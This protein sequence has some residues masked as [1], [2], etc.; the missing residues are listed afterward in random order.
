[1]NWLWRL[2]VPAKLQHFLWLCFHNALP[3]NARRHHC[4]MVAS[5]SCT[6]CSSPIED[7][8]HCLR[9]CPHSIEFWLGLNMGGGDGLSRTWNH[10]N[11]NMVTTPKRFGGLGIREARLTNLALLGKLVWN[12]LHNKD[13]LWVKVLSHKYMG[14]TFMDEQES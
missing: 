7:I 13:K 4:N 2:K 9:D 10:V 6:R 12:M 11:W 8:L 5:P 3:I 1:M 14:N